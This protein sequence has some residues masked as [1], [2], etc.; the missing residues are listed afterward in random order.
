LQIGKRSGK[1]LRESKRVVKH[2]RHG[3]HTTVKRNHLILKTSAVI[4]KRHIE[5][6]GI[7]LRALVPVATIHNHVTQERIVVLERESVNVAKKGIRVIQSARRD[8]HGLAHLENN[9]EI[10]RARLD[11]SKRGASDAILRVEA[12]GQ[13]LRRGGS[14]SR[15]GVSVSGKERSIV[16]HRRTLGGLLLKIPLGDG[17]LKSGKS[18]AERQRNGHVVYSHNARIGTGRKREGTERGNDGVT[19]SVVLSSG[20]SKTQIVSAGGNLNL[21]ANAHITANY[22]VAKRGKGDV[23]EENLATQNGTVVRGVVVSLLDTSNVEKLATVGANVHLL[24]KNY[25]NLIGHF[26]KVKRNLNF[27]NFENL[28]FVN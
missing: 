11:R 4:D 25:F 27:R 22:T 21:I 1:E 7:S 20:I 6:G 16:E 17:A 10:A 24:I 19:L 5:V 15:G 14:L 2:T 9:A 28:K 13:G 18:L 26:I 12:S 3:N 8:E 23:G